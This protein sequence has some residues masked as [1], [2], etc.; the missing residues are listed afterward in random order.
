MIDPKNH[1]KEFFFLEE[2][3]KQLDGLLYYCTRETFML[4]T[5]EGIDISQITKEMI[6]TEAR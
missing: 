1:S 3:R 5:S 2:K 6:I 4:E